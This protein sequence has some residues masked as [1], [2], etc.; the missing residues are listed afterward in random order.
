MT[1]LEL[2]AR[3]RQVTEFMQLTGL[4]SD[5]LEFSTFELGRVQLHPNDFALQD[6][7]CE[8]CQNLLPLAQAKTIL[9]IAEPMSESVQLFTDQVKLGRVLTN[10]ITNAIKYTATGSVRVEAGR[11]GAGSVWIRV[12]DTGIG[13]RLEDREMI[14]DEFAQVR[15]P[16]G[17][18]GKGYGLGL[19]IVRRLVVLMGGTVSIE[20]SSTNGSA[21]I[22]HLPSTCL[23]AV[24]QPQLECNTAST[25]GSAQSGSAAWHSHCNGG[26]DASV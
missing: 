13:I 2:Q 19:S 11:N 22:V 5:L 18:Y 26:A 23:A 16:R 3:R 25:S 8:Q 14:F 17:E 20:N 4:V 9:L 15:G 21:F 6:L 1:A 7:I 10:L 24:A 12:Q